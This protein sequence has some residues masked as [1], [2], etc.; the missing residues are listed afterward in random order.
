MNMRH[1]MAS[2]SHAMSGATVCFV[3][4]GNAETV[5]VLAILPESTKAA[6]DESCSKKLA[7]RAAGMAVKEAKRIGRVLSSGVFMGGNGNGSVFATGVADISMT[8]EAEKR[9]VAS[10]IPRV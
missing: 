9:L 1:M 5:S 4:K 8:P 7:D 2:V 3:R 10:G 6:K